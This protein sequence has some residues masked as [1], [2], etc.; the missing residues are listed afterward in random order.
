M[1]SDEIENRFLESDE[2][3]NRFRFYRMAPW[4]GSSTLM[5]G[6]TV[7]PRSIVATDLW[8]E[9]T[10]CFNCAQQILNEEIE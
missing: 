6:H 8:K 5:C 4:Y 7:K 3:E 10:I 2:M 9:E 1:N